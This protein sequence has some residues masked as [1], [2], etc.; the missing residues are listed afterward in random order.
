MYYF[1]IGVFHCANFTGRTTRLEFMGFVLIA[2]ILMVLIDTLSKLIHSNCPSI[3]CGLVLIL[4]LSSILVRR[5]HDMGKSAWWLF[6]LF[7]PV[8]GLFM[9][10]VFL[11]SKSDGDNKYNPR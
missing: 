7:V 2:S 11:L 5:L 9:V 6:A 8:I 4:P 10:F 3:L 1:M